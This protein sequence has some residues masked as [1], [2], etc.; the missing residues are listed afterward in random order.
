[1]KIRTSVAI[2]KALLEKAAKLSRR[3]RNRSELMENALRAYVARAARRGKHAKDLETI[4]RRAPELNE[5]ALDVL[6]YQVTL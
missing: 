6:G 2:D 1:M 5:E 3:H 4:N